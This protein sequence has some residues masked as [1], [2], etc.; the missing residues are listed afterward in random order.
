MNHYVWSNDG[1]LDGSVEER[2]FIQQILLAEYMEYVNMYNFVETP[3]TSLDWQLREGLSFHENRE[4]Y[5]ACQLYVDTIK[6][7]KEKIEEYDNR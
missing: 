5:E 2:L 7:Y 6:R 3:P 1:Y 4:D